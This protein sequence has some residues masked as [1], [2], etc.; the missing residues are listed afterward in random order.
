RPLPSNTAS[1]KSCTPSGCT[2]RTASRTSEIPGVQTRWRPL[3]D[4]TRSSASKSARAPAAMKNAA[5]AIA[6]RLLTAPVLSAD[7][8]N[9]E[10]T[11]QIGQL[12]EI[13]RPDQV[14]DR[15]LRRLRRENDQAGHA[16]AARQNVDLDVLL[17]AALHGHDA[18]PVGAQLRA[19]GVDDR[20]VV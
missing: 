16:V 8:R 4:T 6:I 13:D 3:D 12:L 7:A 9:S 10:L 15:Q 18:F 20:A 14:D 11:F 17:Q 19:D 5:S 2:I 1:W